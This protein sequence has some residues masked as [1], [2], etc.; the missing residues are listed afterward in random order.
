MVGE[1]GGC[2]LHVETVFEPV[3]A[4]EIGDIETHVEIVDAAGVFELVGHLDFVVGIGQMAFQYGAGAGDNHE[5]GAEAVVLPMEIGE[6]LI[7]YHLVVETETEQV[8]FAAR[9]GVDRH[10]AV[11]VEEVE[12]E[13]LVIEEFG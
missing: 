11:E 13:T 4:H 9:A 2:Q 3:G 5:I 1:I 10:F 12:G 7:A 6:R 8:D